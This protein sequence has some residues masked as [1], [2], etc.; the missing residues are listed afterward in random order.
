MRK[1]IFT[2]C[3]IFLGLFLYAAPQDSLASDTTVTVEAQNKGALPSPE[4]SLNKKQVVAGIAASSIDSIKIEKGICLPE[5]HTLSFGEW[6]LSFL[7]LAIFV[8]LFS[9]LFGTGLKDFNVVEALKEN[10]LAKLTIQNP[11]Y[12]PGSDPDKL[13]DIP[14]TIEVTA[15]TLFALSSP[16]E[17]NH[18]PETDYRPSISR[19]IAFI[20]S[21]LI[22]ILVVCVCCFYIYY[23]LSK[24][25]TPDLAGL[26][27]LLIALGVGIVPYAANKI[28]GAVATKG[29]QY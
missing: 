8:V 28:S 26:S 25:C 17:P 18:L 1:V 2:T 6:V 11:L 27:T 9:L 14:P 12:V 20:S 24:G 16:I 7:P 13:K 4:T 22:I 29:E 21:L 19:Y 15:Q 10:E 23:Y 3:L 5:E